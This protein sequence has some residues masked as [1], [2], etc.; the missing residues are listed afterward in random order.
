[1]VGDDP[2]G[3][4]VAPGSWVYTTRP[5]AGEDS[6]A[7]G[8][9][10]G[11]DLSNL[12]DLKDSLAIEIARVSRTPVSYF[13]VSGQRPAEGTL[14]Q[15]ESGLVG[16]AKSRQ[17]SFGNS[18]EDA[19]MLARRLWNSFGSG[20]QLDELEP[21]STVWDEAE[22][23]NDAV[24][25]EVLKAKSALGVPREQLWLEMGYSSGDI[26][27]M[28]EMVEEAER[29]QGNL[30]EQLLTA[31]ERLPQRRPMRPDDDDAQATD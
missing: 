21:I 25:L 16:K 2:S 4:S 11:E 12:I 1:M 18:W 10:P 9:F 3:V 7:M 13:Q 29:R 28:Q 19:F 30:G 8:Y 15:E 14:K 5:A 31:F 20:P 24:L 23:R 22:T 6:A 17:V 27:A 26:E